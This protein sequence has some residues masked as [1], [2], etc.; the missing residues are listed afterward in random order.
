VFSGHLGFET[1]D[2]LISYYDLWNDTYQDTYAVIFE[3]LPA[4]GDPDDFKYKIRLSDPRLQTSRIFPEFE[5][6]GP[7]S[8]GTVYEY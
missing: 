2:E 4:K 8:S 7:G 1:E 5:P 6:N 3:A